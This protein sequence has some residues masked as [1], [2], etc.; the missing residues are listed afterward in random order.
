MFTARVKFER[1]EGIRYISH[2]DMQRMVQR[3]LRRAHIPMKYSEGFNPHPK[4]AFAMALAVGMTSD[5][6]Y[7]DVELESRVE[8][9]ELVGRIND[10]APAGFIART[11]VVSEEKLPSLTSMVEE[12]GYKITGKVITIAAAEDLIRQIRDVKERDSI[13]QRKRN[14]KGKYAEREIRPLIR[15]LEGKVEGERFILQTVLA[16]GSQENLRPEVVLDLLDP[17]KNIMD[18][19]EGVTIKRVFLGKK[20]GKELI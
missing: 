13:L 7:F 15:Q 17:E 2:L 3:I 8:P 9:E 19:E 16:S 11:A 10:H 12:S 1:G 14:K 4:L 20:N 5:C 18:W 6:E